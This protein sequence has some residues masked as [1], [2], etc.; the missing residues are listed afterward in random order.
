MNFLFDLINECAGYTSKYYDEI[1]AGKLSY[2]QMVTK[3]RKEKDDVTKSELLSDSHPHCLMVVEGVESLYKM[4]RDRAS[5][6][7]SVD[8]LD[9]VILRL[10][11]SSISFSCTTLADLSLT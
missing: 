4:Y 2:S 8:Y 3:Y 10:N 7:L 6:Q 1:G 5:K 9:T 11:V